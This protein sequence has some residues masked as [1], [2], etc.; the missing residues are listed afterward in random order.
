MSTESSHSTLNSPCRADLS[1][2]SQAEAEALAKV[3][4]PST[5]WDIQP[6]FA[7]RLAL[8]NGIP[9]ASPYSA[10]N[11]LSA[12]N[13]QQCPL[14]NPPPANPSIQPSTNPPCRADLS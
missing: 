12:S 3:D 1:R 9:P 14:S 7:D 13:H 2:H 4:Q 6:V 11:Q 8:V 10:N 5:L